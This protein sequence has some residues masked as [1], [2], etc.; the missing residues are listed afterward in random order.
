MSR[1][2]NGKALVDELS[3]LLGDT[4]TTFKTRLLGW[5]NDVIFDIST[6]HDWG[7]HLVK[8]KRLIAMGEEV[9]SLEIPAPLAPRI[10]LKE[11]GNLTSGTDYSALI[12]FIQSNGVESLAGKASA[13]V[14]TLVTQ[15][16]FLLEDIPTSPDPLVSKRRVYVKKGDEPFFLHSEIDDNFT[17]SLTITTNATSEV[18]PPDYESI[19]RLKGSPFFETSPSIYLT[20]KDIDQM[21]LIAQGQWS[22]GNPEFFSPLE[23]NSVSLYPIPAQDM[24][25]SFNYYRNPHKLY[26]SIDSQPDLPIALKPALKAGIISY[27]YEYRDRDGQEI[28][29]ANYENAIVDAINR[30]GRVANIEYTIRDVYGNFN[31][32][33]VN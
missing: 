7:H 31:G 15:V 19:R 6:R 10:T 30:G 3:A 1:A 8:G 22:Q 29:K 20:Y 17:G 27:G 11:G 28:K 21:R 32:F 26:Y 14:T 16:S 33:E 5:A 24:E 2:W 13:V 18:E 25:L 12:T 23:A 4:S 9:H